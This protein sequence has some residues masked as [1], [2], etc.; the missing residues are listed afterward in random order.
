MSL[1][2]KCDRCGVYYKDTKHVGNPDNYQV[3]KPLT[4]WGFDDRKDL[5]IECTKKLNCF[6]AGE[7]LASTVGNN[8][9]Y[10][11]EP[12]PSVIERFKNKFRKKDKNERNDHHRG[13][14][15]SA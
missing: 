1:E 11:V 7:D 3:Y 14:P 4:G 6:M 13:C 10:Y 2:R 5:C 15:Y 8:P 9:I 12:K